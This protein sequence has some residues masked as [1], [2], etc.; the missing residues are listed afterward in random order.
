MNVPTRVIVSTDGPAAAE[1]RFVI[2]M[3]LRLNA[4]TTRSGSGATIVQARLAGW[5]TFPAGS[6]A[7]TANVCDPTESD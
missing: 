5:P 2:V 6:V 3:L 1:P 4:E 7:R